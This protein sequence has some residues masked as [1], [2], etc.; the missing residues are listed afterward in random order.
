MTLRAYSHDIS[1]KRPLVAVAAVAI[2][3]GQSEAGLIGQDERM[4]R[5]MM[6]PLLVDWWYEG[7]LTLLVFFP[8]S[9]LF[10]LKWVVL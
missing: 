10:L 1:L 6:K 4:M 8:G 3:V 2:A 5:M 7:P 9:F